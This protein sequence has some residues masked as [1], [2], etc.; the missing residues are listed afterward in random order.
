MKNELIIKRTMGKE[1]LTATGPE[2]TVY[3]LIDV[4]T[5]LYRVCTAGENTSAI[6]EWLAAMAKEND[7]KDNFAVMLVKAL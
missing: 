5:G 4:K 1:I 6:D 7:V 3:A 2:Q